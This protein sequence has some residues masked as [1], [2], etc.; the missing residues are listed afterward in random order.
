[1]VASLWND[2]FRER[3]AA[4][5]GIAKNEVEDPFLADINRMR[6]DI[7]HHGGVATARNSGRC[8]VLRWFSA[9]DVMH[10]YPEHVAEF[11]HY[12]G[13]VEPSGSFG[14][15]AWEVCGGA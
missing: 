13:L 2:H 8:E 6:N 3:L 7:V 9:G 4:A 12:L 1:M 15:G 5:K 10:V 11:M 14:G